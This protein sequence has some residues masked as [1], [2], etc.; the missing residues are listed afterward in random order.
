MA[1][2]PVVLPSGSVL[3]YGPG[4]TTSSTGITA[5]PENQF[6]FGSIS[7]VYDGCS[8]A[9]AGDLVM[10]KTTDVQSKLV[11]SGWPYLLIDVEKIKLAE[12]IPL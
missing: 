7:Q 2:L 10:W 4:S 5:F 3:I 12:E 1:A 6:N 9:T 8:L 11:Y